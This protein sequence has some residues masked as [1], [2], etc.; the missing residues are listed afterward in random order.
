M[1]KEKQYLDS[2]VALA[3]RAKKT[4]ETCTQRF[5]SAQLPDVAWSRFSSAII[6][7]KLIEKQAQVAQENGR[8][9]DLLAIDLD[10][11]MEN[12]RLRI[13]KATHPLMSAVLYST[14]R[15]QGRFEEQRGE[16]VFRAVGLSG[17]EKEY[18]HGM[19]N[20][21]IDFCA[22]LISWGERLT[23]PSVDPMQASIISTLKGRFVD[24]LG[25]R[26]VVNSIL[27][28]RETLKEVELRRKI[29]AGTGKDLSQATNADEFADMLTIGG[30][31]TT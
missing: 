21:E 27:L 31:T 20:D 13:E 3:D 17:M 16:R 9:L 2:A 23:G 5:A 30:V 6:S 12:L 29:L 11:E 19:L 26:P 1:E 28:L 25:L 7:Q 22:S 10:A 4:Q 18:D 15:E 14:E 8:A 24:S